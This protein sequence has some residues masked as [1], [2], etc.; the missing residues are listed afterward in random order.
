MSLSN[1]LVILS[2]IL[3]NLVFSNTLILKSYTFIQVIL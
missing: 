1:Q 3:V 2:K